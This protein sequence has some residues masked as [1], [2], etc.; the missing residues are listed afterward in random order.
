MKYLNDTQR[1]IVVDL[2]ILEGPE[3]V[4]NP[5]T[6]EK[7]TLEPTAVALYDFI[8]GAEMVGNTGRDFSEAIM[9]FR[10]N[11]PD[12]YYALLD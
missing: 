8:K 5:F 10:F 1:R 12:E 3:V 4:E 6:G 9:L 7:C 11:W 2:E